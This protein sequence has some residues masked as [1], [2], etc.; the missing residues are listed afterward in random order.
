MKRL[1]WITLLFSLFILKAISQEIE[2]IGKIESKNAFQEVAKLY[3]LTLPEGKYQFLK[4]VNIE[5]NGSFIVRHTFT[6]PNLYQIE[7]GEGKRIT[8]AIDRPEEI[9]VTVQFLEDGKWTAKVEGSFGTTLMRQFPS[10]LQQLQVNY[11]AD[12]KVELE[13]AIAKKNEQEVNAIQAKVGKAFPKFVNDLHQAVEEMGNSVAVYDALNYIDANKG[14]PIIEAITGKFVTQ[15]PNLVVTKLMQNKLAEIRG[16]GIG[17]VAPDFT[18]NALTGKQASLNDYRGQYVFMDF[19]ASWCLACRA[20]NPEFVKVYKK[21]KQQ[22]LVFL[23]IGVKDDLS[24][25]KKAVK[26]DALPWTQLN[27]LE[28]DI[29]QIYHISSLPQNLLLD[30]EGKIIARNLKAKELEQRLAALF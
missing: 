15:T 26:K 25:W 29:D 2:I 4:K 16:L 7:V 1:T 19:W 28:S 18:L 27:G 30:P 5:S 12:L 13:R 21:Y 11:F 17:A 6:S 22:N 24:T 9:K 8:L 3:E 20:E 10:K 14:L 23:G